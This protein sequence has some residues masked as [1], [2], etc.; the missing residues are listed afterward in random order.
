MPILLFFIFTFISTFTTLYLNSTIT[1]VIMLISFC[2]LFYLAVSVYDE[3]YQQYV[4]YS[5]IF[6]SFVLSF[7]VIVQSCLGKTPK[8]TFPNPNLVAGYIVCAAVLIFSFLIYSDK[9][10]KIKIVYLAF[11]LFFLYGAILTNSRGGLFSLFCGIF[12]TILLKYKKWGIIISAV[13]VLSIFILLPKKTVVN[14]MKI[15]GSDEYSLKRPEIWMAAINMIKENPL[16]GSGPGNFEILFNKYNFPVDS[17][18]SI[19]RYGKSTR[20]AHNEFLQIA[21]EGGIFVFA[22]YIFILI[23]IF[24]NATVKTAALTA[25]LACLLGHS[26]VDFNLHLPATAIVFIFL[27]ANVLYDKSG[28]NFNL[29]AGYGKYIKVFFA[30]LFIFNLFNYY[31]K[32]FD[33]E[34]YKNKLDKLT[35]KESIKAVDIYKKIIRYSPNDFEYRRLVGEMFYLNNDRID[36]IENLKR[37]IELNP[38]NPFAIMSLAK[39]YYDANEFSK[40]DFY[41]KKVIQIEP[42]YLIARYFLA[43]TSE[44]KDDNNSAL[45]EYKNIISINKYFKD[46]N[47]PSG[48]DKTLIS[49]DM[50]E[51]YNSLGFLYMKIGRFNDA[52][53]NYN[54]SIGINSSNSDT[55]SNIASFYYLQKNYDLA[56]KYANLAV[57]YDDKEPIHLKNLIL[58]YKKLGNEKE[59]TKLENKLKGL[60]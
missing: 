22:A 18:R 49:I 32:P 14:T 50:A 12:I 19:A 56:L 45:S 3:E 47:S 13:I 29:K 52:I 53:A 25:V 42:N 59:I 20:F 9:T 21:V 26:L 28:N 40:A 34:K 15:D 54:M 57:H 17:I 5:L 16:S 48:Y 24:K 37:A 38:N 31:F 58:I 7:I 39:I 44:K 41:L 11:F 43:K 2:L 35:D 10:F 27:T 60:K 33:A 30:V 46:I 4:Y 8:A 6:V 23:V 36:A 1:V 51:V 55:Y